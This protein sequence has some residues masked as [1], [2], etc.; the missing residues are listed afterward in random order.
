MYGIPFSRGSLLANA[1]VQA[2]GTS[3]QRPPIFLRLL[4][5]HGNRFL[6]GNAE[7]PVTGS[8][9][10]CGLQVFRVG[11][12]PSYK[13]LD[14]GAGDAGTGR[15]LRQVMYR[16]PARVFDLIRFGG[17]FAARVIRGKAD[18]ERVRKRPRLAPE[19]AYVLHPDPHFFPYLAN[20]GLLD[21]LA[22]LDEASEHAVEPLR[23]T[24]RTRQQDLSP[25]LDED[26]GRWTE[27]RVVHH[28]APRAPL[29]KL[30]RHRLGP[31]AAAP[32]KAVRR[33]P[34]HDLPGP[35]SHPEE[36]LVHTEEE[37]PHVLED[38]AFR[39]FSV[40]L[41]RPAGTPV[42]I[43]DLPPER[44]VEVEIS[45]P[46]SKRHPDGSVS[47]HEQLVTLEGEP[48]RLFQVRQRSV[49]RPGVRPGTRRDAGPG[50]L[51]RPGSAPG[52]SSRGRRRPVPQPPAPPE[53]TFAPPS[54]S[55]PRSDP[56][57]T[58]RARPSRNIP[59][60]PPRRRRRAR[61]AAPS[62]PSRRAPSGGNV[63]AGGRARHPAVE[64]LRRARATP[65]QRGG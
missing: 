10:G 33:V 20:D 22:W 16:V 14:H 9:H 36:V 7:D 1:G 65:P 59:S 51:C 2:I 30:S 23:K 24:G 3:Q 19:I 5:T 61:A 32:A 34:T 11:A 54:A 25:P 40:S 58:R 63:R 18:H 8:P 60:R 46:P 57:R 56:S 53:T 15:Q 35:P 55:R 45:G 47:E 21:R 12:L 31:A 62:G 64:G 50:V 39:R 29:R 44:D 37:V 38:H 4:D 28:P 41:D 26:D 13:V 52:S 42:E 27:A 49:G 17:Q 48:Q 6:D 43:P